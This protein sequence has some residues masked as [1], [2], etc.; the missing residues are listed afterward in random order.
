[1]IAGL[2]LGADNSTER[3]SVYLAEDQQV[4]TQRASLTQKRDRLEAVLRELYKYKV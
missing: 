4:R 2:S 1:M 3:A